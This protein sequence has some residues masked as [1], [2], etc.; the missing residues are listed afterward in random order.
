MTAESGGPTVLQP[1]ISAPANRIKR[2]VKFMSQML[3]ALQFNSRLLP[4]LRISWVRF[5]A[6][7]CRQL[8]QYNPSNRRVTNLVSHHLVFLLKSVMN[9]LTLLSF[10]CMRWSSIAARPARPIHRSSV[11]Q[12]ACT[13]TPNP[14][15][16]LEVVLEPTRPLLRRITQALPSRG[17]LWRPTRIPLPLRDSTRSIP[18]SSSPA[19]RERRTTIARTT[20]SLPHR[21]LNVSPPLPLHDPHQASDSHGF[22]QHTR[23]YLDSQ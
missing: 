22:L 8:C 1:P 4:V 17:I 7:W 5:I 18:R 9:R 21:M 14:V 2:K 15:V 16:L 19:L 10:G 12:L 20:V 11:K 3:Q 13:S 23:F 6:L